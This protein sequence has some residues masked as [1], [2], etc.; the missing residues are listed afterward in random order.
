VEYTVELKELEPQPVLSKRLKVP[1]WRVGAV[2][3]GVMG[4]VRKRVKARNTEPAGPPFVRYHRM[5]LRIDME[6]GFPVPEAVKGK[7]EV[8]AGELPG[9]PAAVTRHIGP[10][11]TINRAYRALKVW[12]REQGRRAAAPGWEV[13][14]TDPKKVK[15]SSRWETEVIVPLE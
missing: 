13:Y 10:Y 15:D 1:F 8:Q 2:L 11:R 4:E 12:M 5:G 7:R 14:H 6:V 9:G 3:P